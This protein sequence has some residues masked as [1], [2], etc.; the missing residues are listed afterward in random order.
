[1]A[2]ADAGFY[3]YST[4]HIILFLFLGVTGMAFG[5]LLERRRNQG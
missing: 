2:D 4:L 3:A 1:M 5:S